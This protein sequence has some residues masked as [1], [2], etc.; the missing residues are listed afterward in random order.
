MAHEA[1]RSQT[2]TLKM[3]K[4]QI[5]RGKAGQK[6]NSPAM[7]GARSKINWIVSGRLI[8]FHS[9]KKEKNHADHLDLSPTQTQPRTKSISYQKKSSAARSRINP[10]PFLSRKGRDATAGGNTANKQRQR[11]YF[12]TSDNVSQ[13]ESRKCKV[14][15]KKLDFHIFF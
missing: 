12:R 8:I 6:G 11:N 1:S 9:T 14:G 2:V 3:K 7:Q 10:L 15:G 4:G 13:G 5:L